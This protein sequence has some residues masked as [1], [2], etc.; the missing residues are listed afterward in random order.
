MKRGRE[1]CGGIT[2]FDGAKNANRFEKC[3]VFGNGKCG[4]RNWGAIFWQ[5][6]AQNS[7][8]ILRCTF[9]ARRSAK[10]IA[11]FSATMV[12]SLPSFSLCISLSLSLSHRMYLTHNIGNASAFPIIRK[13]HFFNGVYSLKWRMT[14]RYLRWKTLAQPQPSRAEAD[15]CKSSE[16]L[17]ELRISGFPRFWV[18][19]TCLHAKL[20]WIDAIPMTNKTLFSYA[21]YLLHYSYLNKVCWPACYFRLSVLRSASLLYLA[22][23]QWYHWFLSSFLSFFNHQKNMNACLKGTRTPRKGTQSNLHIHEQLFNKYTRLSHQVVVVS[24]LQFGQTQQSLGVGKG[25]AH[26]WNQRRPYRQLHRNTHHK[27]NV[28]QWWRGRTRFQKRPS[29][30]NIVCDSEFSWMLKLMDHLRND[31][32]QHTRTP[33]PTIPGSYS[34]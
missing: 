25:E 20:L 24:S 10:L 6:K 22:V 5:G 27:Y 28:S 16:F 29:E 19:P 33:F 4:G 12:T 11:N 32:M 1:K 30:P 17:H 9:L 7:S 13:L 15:Q 31:V 21:D 8:P 3:N 14:D 2:P 23:I 34:M 18:S 26:N